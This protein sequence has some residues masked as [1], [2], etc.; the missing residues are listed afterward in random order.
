MGLTLKASKFGEEDRLYKRLSILLRNDAPRT[1]YSWGAGIVVV[2]VVASWVAVD[3]A[4]KG[5]ATV[6]GVQKDLPSSSAKSLRVELWKR[7]G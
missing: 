4:L 3:V 5:Q 7:C 1:K 2:V 6:V